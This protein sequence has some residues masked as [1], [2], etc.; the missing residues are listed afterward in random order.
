[1]NIEILKVLSTLV[2]GLVGGGV[3]VAIVNKWRHPS[4]RIKN[5]NDVIAPLLETIKMLTERTN[6][7]MAQLLETNQKLIEANKTRIQQLQEI[8]IL[9]ETIQ[10]QNKKIE[11]MQVQLNEL[12]RLTKKHEQ[13]GTTT[14]N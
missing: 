9:K 5:A 1:M 6:E 7:L 12:I 4:D 3:G 14:E 2:I 13:D 11:R 8:S 10:E